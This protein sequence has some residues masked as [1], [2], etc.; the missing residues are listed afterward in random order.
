MK[1]IKFILTSAVLA[2]LASCANDDNYGAPNS[3]GDCQELTVTNQV[4]EITS[5][6]T[7]TMQQFQGSGVIEAFVTSSDEGGNFYKS[8]SFVSTDNDKGFSMPIDD[9]NLYTK[10]APGQKVFIKLDSLYFQSRSAQT[11]GLQIGA[12]YEGNVGRIAPISYRNI[13]IPACEGSVE[14]DSITHKIKISQAKNDN[15]LNK[16]IKFENVQFTEASLGHNYFAPELNSLG[17][18]T[19]HILEDNEGG[20]IIVRFSQYATF[21]YNQV[22]SGN[23]TI[24]GVLTKYG[25]D[26]Q[27]MVRTESDINMSGDRF[28]PVTSIGGTNIQFLSN[29]SENFES[30]SITGTMYAIGPRSTFPEYINDTPIGPRYWSVT[31]FQGNKYLQM[32]A[33]NTNSLCKA[34]FIVPANLSNATLSF[35]TKDGYFN[36][37]ALKVYYSTNYTPHTSVAN[38]TLVDITSNFSIA[39]GSTN[40]YANNFTNSGSYTINGGGNGFIIF[41]YSGSSPS[42]V[43]T[44]YQ[45][46]DIVVQ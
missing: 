42:G 5:M 9:Y 44:T 22:A 14:E 28:E 6:A 8:I 3:T 35:K 12:N 30:R 15:Y 27:F 31:D 29:F 45:I 32:S 20:S 25:S 19:N 46:D 34:Y 17:G 38:A 23:G 10:F 1:N 18:A 40:G 43:T 11:R 13:I 4:S 33:H 36:G 2:F 7:N 37:N 26:Y 16:L 21:A 39:S 24:K 41:E